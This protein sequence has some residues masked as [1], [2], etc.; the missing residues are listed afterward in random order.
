MQSNQPHVL[1]N[2]SVVTSPAYNDRGLLL[3]Y[4]TS[5][6]YS[7]DFRGRQVYIATFFT[8]SSVILQPTEMPLSSSLFLCQVYTVFSQHTYTSLRLWNSYSKTLLAFHHSSYIKIWSLI[9]QYSK[10]TLSKL[11]KCTALWILKGTQLLCVSYP[12]SS[13]ESNL[14]KWCLFR[15]TYLQFDDAVWRYRYLTVH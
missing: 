4:V 1:R 3:G 10:G 6:R 15:A 14:K 2:T 13:W 11:C 7:Q 5:L 9:G 12:L 8:Y